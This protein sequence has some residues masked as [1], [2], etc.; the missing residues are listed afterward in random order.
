M[1]EDHFMLLE[2]ISVGGMAEVYKAKEYGVAISIL[3]VAIELGPEGV[4]R[5]VQ[6]AGIGFCFARRFHPAMRHAQPVRADLKMRT[7]FNILGPL[8]NPAGA[9]A[10][11]VGV[12]EKRLVGLLAEGVRDGAAAR[13]ASDALY[14][15]K[16]GKVSCTLN[17]AS[18]DLELNEDVINDIGFAYRNHPVPY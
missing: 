10:Q 6:E 2:R 16:Y 4:A 14:T 11:V 8:T 7:V 13:A 15:D 3:G 18:I 5:C 12:F 17:I 1:L 9:G